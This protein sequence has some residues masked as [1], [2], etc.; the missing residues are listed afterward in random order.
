MK[1]E[2]FIKRA[3]K[4]VLTL[5]DT[6]RNKWA[7]NGRVMMII[8]DGVNFTGT[9]TATI[10][11]WL[12]DEIYSC[13]PVEYEDEQAFLD[14]AELPAY[15]KAKDIERIYKLGRDEIRVNN[16]DWS[17]IESSDITTIICDNDGETIALVIYNRHG[18]VEGVI[19]AEDFNIYAKIE[20]E[21]N[22][23]N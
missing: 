8:P 3:G 20:E 6:E 10:P 4:H 11:E 18:D 13:D 16:A 2:K 17:L 1:F 9:P 14:R 21:N 19:F 5:T 22:N 23:V 12:T 15:G 7:C